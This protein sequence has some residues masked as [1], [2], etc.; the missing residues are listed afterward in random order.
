LRPA[1]PQGADRVSDPYRSLNPRRTVVEALI[2]GPSTT[3]ARAQALERAREL[4]ALVRKWTRAR[5]SAY[6]TSSPA[7]SASASASP[8]RLDDG[9]RAADRRRRRCRRWDVSVQAQV[10]K[11]LE[12][13]R[14]RLN[15]GDC[16]SSPTTCAS[17][18]RSCD[19][20]WFMSQGKVVEYGRR[21]PHLRRAAA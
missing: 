2:E 14:A 9:A 21:L 1:A 15:L 19:S 20:W 10:L 18:R 12:E 8:A 6:R 7:A 5:W 13:I 17:R 11:L 3:P 16:C 4:L